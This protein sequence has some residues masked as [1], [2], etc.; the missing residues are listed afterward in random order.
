ME[1]SNQ[2]VKLPWPIPHYKNIPLKKQENL[3]KW[4]KEE[5]E[6]N[7]NTKILKSTKKLGH[8]SVH[9]RTSLNRG[10]IQM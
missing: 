6:L 5:N 9:R 7:T 8:K 2:D 3:I 10:K 1:D 4:K